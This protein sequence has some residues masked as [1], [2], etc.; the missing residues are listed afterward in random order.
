MKIGNFISGICLVVLGLFSCTSEEV[1]ESVEGNASLSIVLSVNDVTT[2]AELG[3]TDN[4]SKINNFYV[5]IFNEKGA[6]IDSK[7]ISNTADESSDFIS[8]TVNEKPG[9]KVDFPEV[10]RSQGKVFAV[11]VA[12]ALSVYSD[13]EACTTYGQLAS[14]ADIIIETNKFSDENLAKAGVSEKKNFAEGNLTLTVP[15]TQLCARIDFGNISIIDSKVATKAGEESKVEENYLLCNPSEVPVNIVN[16][17]KA[18]ADIS[19]D[20]IYGET[21]NSGLINYQYWEELSDLAKNGYYYDVHNGYYN[22]YYKSRFFIYSKTVTTT[23]EEEQTPGEEGGFTPSSIS[24]TANGKTTILYDDK[25][26]SSTNQQYNALI[27]EIGTN[28]SFYTYEFP[29]DQSLKMRIIGTYSAES[30]GGSATKPVITKKTVYGI[31]KQNRPSG[32]LENWSNAS[33]P[34]SENDI[35]NSNDIEWFEDA[36]SEEET[37]SD[38]KSLTTKSNARPITYELGWAKDVRDASGK[39]VSLLHGYVYELSLRLK[40]NNVQFIVKKKDW[41]PCPVDVTYGDNSN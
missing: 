13:L 18:K 23:T 30:G 14:S 10:N 28:Q 15:L 11:V 39:P 17:L 36:I 4:E 7:I 41:T 40:V 9:Y 34:Q 24:Y 2:K 19:S 22:N 16:Q 29:T 12:N 6:K 32:W 26:N 1:I 38:L 20:L 27:G 8:V 5:A 21:L 35:E 25:S 31:L 33:F 37:T 3:V